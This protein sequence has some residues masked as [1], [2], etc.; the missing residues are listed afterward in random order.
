MAGELTEAPDDLGGAYAAHRQEVTFAQ[1]DER[2]RARAISIR[3]PNEESPVVG[4]R[5]TKDT[6]GTEAV[7]ASEPG[8]VSMAERGG[9][10]VADVLKGTPGALGAA[11]SDIGRGIVESPKAIGGGVLAALQETWE[12]IDDAA[13]YLN[14][15]TGMGAVGKPGERPSETA[16]IPQLDKP[17]SL[18]GNF[19]RTAAQFLTGFGAASRIARRATGMAP[20]A[21]RGAVEKASSTTA[22]KIAGAQAKG[23][24]SMAVA[25]DPHEQR[26]SN[27]VEQFA[28]EHPTLQNPISEYLKADPADSNAE[29]RLKNAIEGAALGAVADSVIVAFRGIRA[30]MR[31]RSAAAPPPKTE[32][33]RAREQY[34]EVQPERDFMILGDPDPRAAMFKVEPTL[35]ES[36]LGKIQAA[37]VATETGVP[38]S[39]AATGVKRSAED[40]VR[41]RDLLLRTKEQPFTPRTAEDLAAADLAEL[42]GEHSGLFE[43]IKAMRKGVAQPKGL[44]LTGWLVSKGGLRD[45]QG[46]VAALG[47]TPRARP[48]L[49]SQH[50]MELDA[51]ALR[52]WEAGFFPE[53]TDRPTINQFLDALNGDFNK[54]AA[55]VLEG[56]FD[57]AAYHRWQAVQDL[58]SVLNREGIPST[59]SDAE[60]VTALERVAAPQPAGA[61]AVEGVPLRGGEGSTLG[62]KVLLGEQKLLVNFARINSAEDVKQVLADAAEAMAPQIDEAR[63]GVR[64]NAATQEAAD[65]LGLTVEQ[66]LQRRS[67]QAL[68]AEE[69]LAARQLWAA[70]AERLL[71]TAKKAAEPNAGPV[72]QYNFR[73]MLAV[74]HAIQSEVLAARAEA[75]RALQQWS[76]PA[77]GGVE[78][79]RSIKLMLDNMGGEAVSKELAARLAAL[80]EQGTT[81]AALGAAARKGAMAATMDAVKEAYVMGMLWAPPT[82]IVNTMSNAGVAFMQIYERAA[83]RQMAQALGREVGEGGVAEGEALAM[84]YG[85]VTGLKDAFRL[86]GRALRTGEE[87]IGTGGKVDVRPDAISAAAF[88]KAGLLGTAIDYLGHATRAPGRLLLGE[89]TFFKSIG[90]RME[91]HAQALRQATEEGL[92]GPDR[93]RRMAELVANPPENLHIAAVDAATYSTFTNA[94]G[95]FASRLSLL[96]NSSDFNPMFVVLPFLRTPANILRYTFERTPL[97]PLVGQW[98]QDIAAG[99]ARADVAL[100]R[101]AT[102]SAISFWA[103]DMAY[104]GNIS[105][106]GPKDPGRREALERQGWQPNS[107]Y[108]GGK[109]VSYNRTDPFG[110]LMGFAATLAET[111]RF[112]EID[113]DQLD[114]WQ[115]VVAAGAAAVGKQVLDKTYLQGIA[116][117]IAAIEDPERFAPS[118]VQ[119]LVT[120]FVP[121]GSALRFVERGLDPTDREANNPWQAVEAMLPGLSE[122]L[123]PKRDLWGKEK[124]PQEVY[125]RTVDLLSPA[126]VTEAKDSPIDAAMTDNNMGVERIKKKTSFKGVEMNLRDW[127]EVY[128]RYVVLAGNELKLKSY[129]NLGAKD[130]LNEVVTGKSQFSKIYNMGT[131]GKDGG[132]AAFIERTIQ[133]YRQE[134][135]AAILKDSRFADFRAAWNE[136]ALEKQENRNVIDERGNRALPKLPVVVQ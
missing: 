28:A 72:D 32:L 121:F 64:S 70:S 102:G 87:Q 2:A 88:G 56:S 116:R 19:L 14:A 61:A 80:G 37:E 24:T 76:I 104:S 126:K 36:A 48:G 135:A 4:D 39:V 109:W 7:P 54:T 106:S 122:G 134:A 123:T 101:M 31:S 119:Q 79:A 22:G 75:A 12:T 42:Q 129:D 33:D 110:M 27:L 77:G 90:Y 95:S 89:D 81:P 9:M 17:D 29:G 59:A 60:I 131:P 100:A 8:G 82:H 30:V 20:A 120:G 130:F 11:A 113:P 68:N 46:E 97:A 5:T 73:K 136:R 96:R 40:A 103:A 43:I 112:G 133:E 38:T 34:G 67:G 57:E 1:M 86:T 118:Y 127:P 52:S 94:P 98:R 58:E 128:D 51:A 115:E 125:G 15:K 117:V 69:S 49:L 3:L 108:I 47:V 10:L 107:I 63:R 74:H 45:F 35:G 55:R 50:G 26:L 124:T 18:T 93:I 6:G 91:V 132:K 23:A 99:G 66:L 92:T 25:H 111:A 84:A 62:G 105:G 71:A 65:A 83:G 41:A 21:V 16:A 78:Q 114:E 53:L 44:T 85:L 13:D